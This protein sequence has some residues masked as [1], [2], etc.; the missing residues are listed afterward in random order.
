MAEPA[1]YKCGLDA[2]VDV[3]GGKWKPLILWAL[4]AAP[5]RFGELRRHV[6]GV[7]EKMLI[8]QLRELEA[9]GIVHREVYHQV[10][11]RVEYSLTDL[12]AALNVALLPLGE[13][14][15]DHLAEIEATRRR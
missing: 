13:W 10:P 8:Q 12:G 7:T 5:L 6:G 3:V 2:A 9:R 15:D 14:G 1:P 4:H 11:P